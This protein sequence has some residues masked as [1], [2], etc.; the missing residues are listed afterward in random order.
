MSSVSDALAEL[1]GAFGEASVSVDPQLL[2]QYQTATFATEQRVL[3]VV[4]PRDT[5][6]VQQVVRVANRHRLP[7][8]PISRGR[9]WGL[10]SR[11]PVCDAACVVDLSRMNCIRHFSEAQGTLTVEPGVTFQQAADF[12]EANGSRRFLACT[13]GPPD[14]SVLANALE[15]GDG[16][17]PY[18]DR[19][20][21]CCGL[22]AVLPTGERIETGLEAFDHTETGKL[23]SFGLGPGVE[24]LLFQSNLAIVTRM[25]V[26]LAR[27]PPE[28]LRVTLAMNS[29]EE[30]TAATAA[31]HELQQL[32]VV[33]DTAFSIW[34][35][36]RLLSLLGPYP[37]PEDGRPLAPEALLERLPGIWKGTKWIGFVGIYAPS[38]PHALASRRMIQQAL[39][40]KVS[41]LL[42]LNAL[43]V[44]AAEL[45]KPWLK[46]FLGIDV[47]KLL[48]EL[49]YDSVY[50]GHP[51]T[52][53]VASLYWRKRGALPSGFDLDRDRCGL[54]WICVALPYE[55]QHI[56]RVTEIVQNQ[57]LSLG[58]EPLCMFFNMNARMLKSFV[59][60][61]YDRDAPGEEAA[62]LRC[63]DSVWA[64]LIAAGYPPVRLGIQSMH[65]APDDPGLID[66]VRRLKTELD[67][68]DILAPGRYDFR[69]HWRK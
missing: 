55:G 22:E 35:V 28:F 19:A 62:A 8:Y 68:N 11:V 52:A 32:G 9:N 46:K 60:I 17:G 42:V 39:K 33:G 25:T 15:R 49:Y 41:K 1:R 29:V 20:R 48:Q 53:S 61:S 3:A 50:L 69:Q 58:L 10:G 51:T 27:R 24:G 64:E 59:V 57:A 4:W 54:H 43:V 36:Y 5:A 6:E 23:A 47:D 44:R 12:L 40:G 16:T 26:W 56:A 63:H 37:W 67:P 21:Y 34:N 66:L 13:G 38:L 31:L 18:G 45:T 2:G 30:L 14:S 7:L 65:L